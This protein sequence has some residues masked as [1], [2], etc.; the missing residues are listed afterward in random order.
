ML[1]RTGSENYCHKC[2]IDQLGRGRSKSWCS[3]V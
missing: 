3:F 1:V 2:I